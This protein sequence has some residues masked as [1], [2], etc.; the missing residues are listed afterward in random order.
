MLSK[1]VI[2]SLFN[3]HTKGLIQEVLK[4]NNDFA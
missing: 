4:W 2:L 1:L 3:I